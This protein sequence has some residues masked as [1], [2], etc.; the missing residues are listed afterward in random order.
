VT[1][2]EREGGSNQGF[3]RRVLADV[4]RLSAVIVEHAEFG[5]YGSG[6]A[7]VEVFLMRGDGSLRRHLPMAKLNPTELAGYLV[8]HASVPP[9]PGVH[10][11]PAHILGEVRP[12]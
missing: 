5:H 7:Y 2:G 6:D 12:R 10:G 9:G 11:F 1:R 8:T 3:L 4:H